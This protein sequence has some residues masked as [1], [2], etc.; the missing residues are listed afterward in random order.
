MHFVRKQPPHRF[1]DDVKRREQQQACLDEGGEAFHFAMAIEMISVSRLIRD[2]H[3]KI[4]DHRGDQI[5]H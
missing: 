2:A 5:E 3:R 1:I 4:S